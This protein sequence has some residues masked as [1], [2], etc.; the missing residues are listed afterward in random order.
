LGKAREDRP[1]IVGI[2]ISA[3]PLSSCDTAFFGTAL[4]PSATPEGR[5]RNKA[6][7]A[8]LK[9]AMFGEVQR[10]FDTLLARSGL[11]ALPDFFV[12]A[13]TLIAGEGEAPSPECAL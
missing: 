12:D 9:Q 1:A 11:P 5:V 2:G 10:Y 3:L 8:N 7:N 6:M 4:P 13:I